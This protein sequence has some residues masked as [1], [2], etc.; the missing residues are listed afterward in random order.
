MQSMAILAYHS[1]D[2]SGSVV[3]VT[4]QAFAD[5]MATL[6][7]LG[8]RGITLRDAVAHRQTHG[9]WPVESVVITFDDGFAN[10]YERGLP[11]LSH[12]GFS[13]TVFLVSAFVGRYNEWETPPAR[14]GRCAV[15][16]WCQ[17]RELANAGWELGGHTRTHPDLRTLGRDRVEQEIVEGKHEIEAQLDRP[18]E[19][20]AY[21][22]G[23][24][25]AD[26]ASIVSREFRAACTTVLRRASD[27]ALHRLPRVDAYYIRSPRRLRKIVQGRLDG[28]LTLR[29]WGRIG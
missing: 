1:L 17:A 24:V 13:A 21:P 19:T 23:R 8:Y 20:F 18:V 2:S 12:H 14:L 29:R 4:P 28:Y 5:Q 10:V 27:E 16:S 7:D 26:A 15:V 25:T 3:S 11:V 9:C 22:Y 6:A